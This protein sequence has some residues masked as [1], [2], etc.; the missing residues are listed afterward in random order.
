MTA[1]RPMTLTLR[2]GHTATVFGAT[3][4]LGRYIVNRLGAFRIEQLRRIMLTWGLQ[5]GKDV[6]WLCLSA[7]KWPSATLRSL[8]TLVGSSSLSVL[9]KRHANAIL[10]LHRSTIFETPPLSKRV[11]ATPTSYTI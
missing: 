7:R 8:A 10:T 3:G 5:L 9:R 2:L 4:Q 1:P 11:S 6:L